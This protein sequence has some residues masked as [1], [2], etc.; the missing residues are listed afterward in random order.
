MHSAAAIDYSQGTTPSEAYDRWKND[1]QPPS[2][3]P[4]ALYGRAIVEFAPYAHE[5]EA[6]IWTPEQASFQAKVIDDSTGQ[7]ECGQEV[8]LESIEGT[9]FEYEGRR[10][11]VV[12]AS[13]ILAILE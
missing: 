12:E 8:A 2:V 6:G 5:S 11:C 9:N 7:L 1:W 4:L 3:T 13:S 10:L